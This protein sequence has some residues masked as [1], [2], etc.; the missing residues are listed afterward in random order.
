M[1]PN[2]RENPARKIGRRKFLKYALAAGGTAGAVL[3]ANELVRRFGGRK[4]TFIARLRGY[5][6]DLRAYI[7]AGFKE[8][9][10]TNEELAGK[11]ILLKP[12]LVEPHL[13]VGH[14][15]THPLVVKA[16]V[17]AF[18]HL[19]AKS[20]TVAEGPGHRRDWYLI[21]EE[22]GYS[23]ILSEDKAPFIDLNTAAVTTVKNLG[24]YSSLRQLVVP[25]LVQEADVI[26]SMPKMKTHHWVGATLAMKNMFGIMPG[27][28]YGWPK[29]VLHFE[30]VN[31]TILDINTSV[32]AH[33]AIVD[34]IVGM[35]GDGPI[36]GTPVE[37]NVIVI[38]R[39]FPAVDATCARIMG[40]NP[41]RIAYLTMAS[42]RLGPIRE[43]LIEQRGETLASVRKD[44]EL[45]DKIPAHQGI[46]L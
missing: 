24:R 18:L 14:I 19:G 13:G 45:V 28:Y 10:I 35:Q 12:N 38:G 39:N 36:M 27:L 32:K 17:E 16:A 34:G 1:P 26:V 6:D 43:S 31:E 41:R 9:G 25:R 15:N 4:A 5:H 40:L 3:A 22:S 37:S 21:L 33:L 11:T 23:E 20:V 30:G 46:R 8:L 44:F 29:N 42:R 7:L 2:R